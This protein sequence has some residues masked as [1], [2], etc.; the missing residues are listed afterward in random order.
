[1]VSYSDS[2]K[3]VFNDFTGFV[4]KYMEIWKT[5]NGLKRYI[6][7]YMQHFSTFKDTLV[8]QSHEMIIIT[9]G[10]AD[11]FKS[12]IIIIVFIQI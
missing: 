4:E 1:M 10:F 3:R 6:Y 9:Q 5:R 7:I 2:I 11:G 12:Y 8:R